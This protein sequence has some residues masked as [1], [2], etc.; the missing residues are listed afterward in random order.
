MVD[1]EAALGAVRK[2]RP[3]I[4][5]SSSGMLWR[6]EGQLSGLRGRIADDFPLNAVVIEK[7]KPSS[8]LVVAV[9][10]GS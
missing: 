1:V 3:F 8:R 2:L 4:S 9:V 5:L 7:V 6:P 10:E